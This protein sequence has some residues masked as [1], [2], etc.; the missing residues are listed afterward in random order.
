MD[1]SADWLK[2]AKRD[3]QSARAQLEK[4]F[5]EWACF[6]AQQASEKALKAVYQKLGADVW[7]HSLTDLCKGL[8][9]KINVSEELLNKA[10]FLDKFYIPARYPNNWISGTPADYITEGDANDATGFAE[11][12]LQFCDR[13]LAG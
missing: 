2:Q 6:I 12:I 9:E 8:Q 1:R 11:E 7:G 5:Y 4:G 10:R 3:L 13:I